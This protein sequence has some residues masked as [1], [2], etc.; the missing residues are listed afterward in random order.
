M[1][2]KAGI[3]SLLSAIVLGWV[4][5]PCAA[6]S[7]PEKP[8]KRKGMVVP[9]ELATGS[10]EMPVKRHHPVM[11]PKRPVSLMLE[12]GPYQVVDFERGWTRASSSEAGTTQLALVSADAAQTYHFRLVSTEAPDEPAWSCACAA[13][14]ATSTLGQSSESSE[15]RIPLSGKGRLE[16][17]L[18]RG[19]GSAP[20]RLDLDHGIEFGLIPA[21][22][23]TGS[24]TSDESMVTIRGTDRLAQYPKIGAQRLTGFAL[25]QGEQPVGA[26]DLFKP[27]VLIGPA[28]PED[29][30]SAFVAA[31]AALLL[32]EDLTQSPDG[33]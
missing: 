14:A 28:L 10:L 17:S 24:L 16:C 3:A 21:Y 15:L 11:L 20:W 7:E 32:F 18:D 2:A 8:K 5:Q 31:G 6:A 33:W 23:A 13:V 1:I 29:L 27:T 25:Y 4:A 19:N 12:F 9:A 30:R 26:V 22:H